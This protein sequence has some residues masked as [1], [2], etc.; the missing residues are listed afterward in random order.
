[1]GCWQHRTHWTERI[2]EIIGHKRVFGKIQVL[3]T[4]IC[5]TGPSSPSQ[6]SG[7]PVDAHV[8][9][10]GTRIIGLNSKSLLLSCLPLFSL[11]ASRS[12]HCQTVGPVHCVRPSPKA[13]PAVVPPHRTRNQ[14]TLAYPSI[15]TDRLG[16]W[17]YPAGT[18][19]PRAIDRAIGPEPRSRPAVCADKQP[20][21]GYFIPT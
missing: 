5:E 7:T 3:T 11:S 18:I 1:M 10:T 13:P 17:R 6:R 12:V 15:S 14:V 21:S 19:F 9:P 4:S 16:A 2:G 8:P 20:T